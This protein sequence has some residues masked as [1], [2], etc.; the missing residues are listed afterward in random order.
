[1]KF[2]VRKH[3]KRFVIKTK[4]CSLNHKMH[5]EEEVPLASLTTSIVETVRLLNRILLCGVS[6]QL[7]N[8]N[9]VLIACPPA[10]LQTLEFELCQKWCLA[11]SSPSLPLCEL[12]YEPLPLPHKRLK[13][14]KCHFLGAQILTLIHKIYDTIELGLKC[15]MCKR[16]G[17]LCCHQK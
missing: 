15:K 4:H 10:R 17:W 16:F 6:F 14:V 3:I 5:R 2:S 8:R 11:F 7:C 1:M 12:H 9:M 13:R